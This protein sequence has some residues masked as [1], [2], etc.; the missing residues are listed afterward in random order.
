LVG[1]VVGAL[2]CAC[3]AGEKANAATTA[4]GLRRNFILSSNYDCTSQSETLLCAD[5]KSRRKVNTYF[6]PIDFELNRGPSPTITA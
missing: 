3:A 2:F 6:A 1:Y 4:S 5:K